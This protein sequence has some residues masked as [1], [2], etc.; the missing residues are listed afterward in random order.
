MV[1]ALEINGA[2]FSAEGLKSTKLVRDPRTHNGTPMHRFYNRFT[3]RLKV[4]QQPACIRFFERMANKGMV[5]G[6][7]A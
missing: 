6:K 5:V 2:P 3:S 1:L 7:S 4:S